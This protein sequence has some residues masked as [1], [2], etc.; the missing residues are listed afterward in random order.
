MTDM[1]RLSISVSDD[2]ERSI[3]ELRK[4]D[5]F[6]RCSYAEIVRQ[7]ITKGLSASTCTNSVNPSA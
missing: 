7:L 5:E 4:T 3:I 1:K 2:M 6:C